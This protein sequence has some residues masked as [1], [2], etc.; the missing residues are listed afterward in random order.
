MKRSEV[1]EQV[2]MMPMKIKTQWEGDELVAVMPAW[3]LP[4]NLLVK[5][6][7]TKEAVSMLEALMLKHWG[8]P[9]SPTPAPDK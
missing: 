7:N 8:V 6:R 5:G 2:V 3:T 9:S 4:T 1:F